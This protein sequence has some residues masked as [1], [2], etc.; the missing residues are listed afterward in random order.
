MRFTQV[1]DKIS[2]CRPEERSDEEPASFPCCAF[3]KCLLIKRS[4]EVLAASVS[5]LLA[6]Y[7]A[8]FVA[9][10]RTREV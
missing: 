9:N 10:S 7:P 1:S 4:R 8:C 5:H 2:S 6:S 3:A